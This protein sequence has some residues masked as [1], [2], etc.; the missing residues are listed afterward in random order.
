M[1]A[2]ARED[3]VSI[4]SATP[5]VRCNRH[6]PPGTRQ[7]YHPHLAGREIA[8]TRSPTRWFCLV[9]ET[10]KSR[11]GASGSSQAGLKSDESWSFKTYNL[12]EKSPGPPVHSLEP[13]SRRTGSGCF[14]THGKLVHQDWELLAE[15]PRPGVTSPCISSPSHSMGEY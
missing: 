4:S 13:S 15:D 3:H 8:Y 2:A 1:E 14:E 12:L 10:G 5:H 6:S 11:F 7:G 9:L